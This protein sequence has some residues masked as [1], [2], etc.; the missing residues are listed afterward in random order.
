[1]SKRLTDREKLLFKLERL[2]DP[3]IEEV[4]KYISLMENTRPSSPEPASIEIPEIAD[5]FDDDL[6]ASL[7]AKHENQRAR[8]V[9]EWESTRRGVEEQTQGYRSARR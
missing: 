8:Q 3:E 5:S 2:T 1:M 4:L 9:F 7:S 6:L